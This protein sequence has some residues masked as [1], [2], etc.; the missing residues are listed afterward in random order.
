[1]YKHPVAMTLRRSFREG[2]PTT[3]SPDPMLD[4]EMRYT[5]AAPNQMFSSIREIENA[6]SSHVPTAPS[7]SAHNPIVCI[8]A[9]TG[10]RGGP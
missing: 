8:K 1:M 10:G 4:L 5:K 6:T 7:Q 3:N 2:F 9:A